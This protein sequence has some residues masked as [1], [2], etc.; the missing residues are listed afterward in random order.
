MN[1]SNSTFLETAN[2]IAA[3]LCRDALWSGDRCNWLGSAME[4]VENNWTVVHR[5][6]GASLYDGTSGIALFL[7]RLFK[8]SPERLY[9]VTAMGGMRQALSRLEDF[10]PVAHI[11]FYSGLPG[12]AYTLL[13]L[14][15][16]FD[17]PPFTGKAFQILEGL[18]QEDLT[19]QGLDVVSGAAGLIPVLLNIHQRHPKDFL[20]DLANR[21]ANYLLS[22][23]KQ[24][25]HGLSW[26]TLNL[27]NQQHLTGFSHGTAGIAWAF[28][29][30]NQLT[31]QEQFWNAAEQAFQ[32]ERY[33]YSSEQENWPD[34]RN[35]SQAVL[36]QH[37]S[38]NY[39]IAWCHGAPGIGLSRLRACQ[40][41][42]DATCKAEAEAA[43]RTTISSLSQSNYG[44]WDNYSLC[45]GLSGNADVLVYANQILNDQT[46][47][48]MAE[49]VGHRG[50][51]LYYKNNLPWPC[52]IM[53]G[54]ETPNLMLGLAGIGYFY[55]R[56]HDSII[57][58]SVLIIV[59]SDSH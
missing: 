13:E 49:Q 22:K 42:G 30:L 35:F 29:E 39:G 19:Q 59:P 26:N 41:L 46:Y 56:L 8:H 27:S 33:W 48:T 57:T 12:I 58:P 2:G 24:S 7:A 15:E 1:S 20:L 10:S 3:K 34:L 44:G 21:L 54:G 9:R 16:I 28:L 37:S 5:A 45:H 47:K 32:Y 6:A 4:F 17:H 40:L 55:L 51:E 52:G 36:D 11:G 14:G 18:S 31:G 23:A 43:L 25:D 50:I 38:L 53:G